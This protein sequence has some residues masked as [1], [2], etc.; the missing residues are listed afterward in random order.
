VL[1]TLGWRQAAIRSNLESHPFVTR[2][3][4]LLKALEGLK[5]A[6]H[7]CQSKQIADALAVAKGLNFR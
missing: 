4:A 2:A 3:R 6:L 1:G 5:S 7:E